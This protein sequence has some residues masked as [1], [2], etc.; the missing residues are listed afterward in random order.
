[1]P[2]ECC[3]EAVGSAS[4]RY[5]SSRAFSEEFRQVL[6]LLFIFT[7]IFTFILIL[8]IVGPEIL[9]RITRLIATATCRWRRRENSWRSRPVDDGD[10]RFVERP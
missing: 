4:E 3:P 9:N 2:A 10:L 8:L 1:M 7:F 5:G 6:F